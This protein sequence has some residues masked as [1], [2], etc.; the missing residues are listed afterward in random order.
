[1]SPFKSDR[2]RKSPHGVVPYSYSIP[3]RKLVSQSSQTASKRDVAFLHA[4][5]AVSN[6]LGVRTPFPYGGLSDRDSGERQSR[7]CAPRWWAIEDI[8]V[9]QYGPLSCQIVKQRSLSPAYAGEPFM[10]CN[11]SGRDLY[12]ARQTW[13]C[14]R[15]TV[16]TPKVPPS[17]PL[18]PPL[19]IVGCGPAS[20]LFLFQWMLDCISYRLD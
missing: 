7:R 9:E 16:T 17:P 4:V 11:F 1:M 8:I 3:W 18:S 15:Q 20:M 14:T 12:N 2:I 19:N 5:H 13:H 6:D 10:V